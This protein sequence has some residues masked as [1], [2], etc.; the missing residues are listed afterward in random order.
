MFGWILVNDVT[1]NGFRINRLWHLKQLGI[2]LSSLVFTVGFL[3]IAIKRPIQ[4]KYQNTVEFYEKAKD[5][6]S[7]YEV[8][9]VYINLLSFF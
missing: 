4:Q 5:E 2:V 1:S 9:D 8:M 7:L 6:V 3:E